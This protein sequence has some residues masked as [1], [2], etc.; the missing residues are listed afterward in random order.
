MIAHFL[1]LHADHHLEEETTLKP[2]RQM[3]RCL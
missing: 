1:A 3:S 2:A